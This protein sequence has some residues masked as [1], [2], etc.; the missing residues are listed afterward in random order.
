MTEG[1]PDW[2]RDWT[3]RLMTTL[4]TVEPGEWLKTDD[5]RTMGPHGGPNAL[6]MVA[7]IRHP[8]KGGI[9]ALWIHCGL[10]AEGFGKL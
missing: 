1:H 9:G 10:R 4:D 7:D 5:K 8:I 6:G 3:R 2:C